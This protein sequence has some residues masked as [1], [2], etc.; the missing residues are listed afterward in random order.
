LVSLV[1]WCAVALATP[2]KNAKTAP[3]PAP[4]PAPVADPVPAEL[5]VQPKP[6]AVSDAKV[7]DTPPPPGLLPEDLTS[8]R[9]RVRRLA[10]GLY[11]HLKPLPGEGRFQ[12]I[13]VLAFTSEGEETKKRDVGKVVS[14]ELATDLRRDFGLNLV[15]RERID[16][17]L[18]EGYLNELG[19][20]DDKQAVKLGQ[21]FSAQALVLGSVSLAGTEFLINARIVS[22]Q[23]GQVFA[24]E[25]EKVP[26]EGVISF[27]ADAVVLRSRSGAVFRSVLI[28]G[29][30]QL[31][32]HQD[33]KGYVFLAA[34][35]VLGA[36]TLAME[37]AALSSHNQ[38]R[39]ASDPV[40][41]N[42]FINT[43]RDF[44]SARDALAVLLGV[45]WGFNVF[46]AWLNG[47]TFDPA[48]AGD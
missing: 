15:E 46:D 43:E 3:P 29:W 33:A 23:T 25:Q 20:V 36:A 17:A 28:P 21:L 12:T 35:V 19:L 22:T 45:A 31:Y 9:V 32:N 24:A 8:T 26:A 34:A 48:R 39:A 38:Y 13:A 47:K 41:Q 18:N 4:A 2:S 5:T 6:A 16:A 44:N 37:L 14:A 40:S 7:V 30:G 11:Q 42:Q 1:L 10:Y 27:A